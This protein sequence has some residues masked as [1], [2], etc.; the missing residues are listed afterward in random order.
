MQR[1]KKGLSQKELADRVELGS[2]T[3]SAIE[4]GSSFTNINNYLRIAD[5][6]GITICDLFSEKENHA[7]N[8]DE[9]LL[10]SLTPRTRR[11]VKRIML[12]IVREMIYLEEHR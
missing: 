9:D 5:V 6:L 4:N 11:S 8:R 12:M 2:S 3:I 1:I 7:K 10:M